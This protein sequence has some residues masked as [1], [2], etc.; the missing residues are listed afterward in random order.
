MINVGSITLFSG[1]H[2]SRWKICTMGRT[3]IIYNG[4]KGMFKSCWCVDDVDLWR[5]GHLHSVQDSSSLKIY[6]TEEVYLYSST[7]L[8]F[9]PLMLGVCDT[10]RWAMICFES[11]IRESDSWLDSQKSPFFEL[12]IWVELICPIQWFELIWVALFENELQLFEKKNKSWWQ[13][14]PIMLSFQYWP[15]PGRVYY[16]RKECISG[17]V[18]LGLR[19]SF[20]RKTNFLSQ[21]KMIQRSSKVFLMVWISQNDWPS[22]YSLY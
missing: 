20:C 22:Q 1:I 5:F 3:N 6:E 21:S 18:E 8:M 7:A 12:L 17:Y 4:K 9:F 10:Q 16:T 2:S 14:L 19:P 13:K 11:T 15:K